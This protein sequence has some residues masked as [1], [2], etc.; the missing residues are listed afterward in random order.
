MAREFQT[1][2]EHTQG[3]QREL[4]VEDDEAIG[5]LY[6]ILVELRKISLQLSIVTGEVID[7]YDLEV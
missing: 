7:K 6:K 2:P 4:V 3:G 5:L 1:G